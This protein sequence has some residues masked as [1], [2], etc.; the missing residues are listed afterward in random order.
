MTLDG[1]PDGAYLA[2]RYVDGHRHVDR[3]QVYWDDGRVD[4]VEDGEREELFRFNAQEVEVARRAIVES[5]LPA[6]AD[7]S[8]DDAYDTASLTY[9]WRAGGRT[10]AVVNSAY[11]A[12]QVDEIERLESLLVELEEQA[13]VWPLMADE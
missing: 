11:P 5:G 3:A 1:L 8:R 2:W 10:G 13:G 7:R 6:A 12:E 4:A 9:W